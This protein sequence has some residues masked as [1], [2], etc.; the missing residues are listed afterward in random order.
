M[1]KNK[2]MKKF[3]KINIFLISFVLIFMAM[4]I[5]IIDPFFHYHKPFSFLSYKL[6]SKYERYINNGIVKNFDYDA[7][8]T[9]TSMT[10]NFKSSQFDKLFNVNSIKVPFSGGSYKEINDNVETALKNNKDI[11]YILRGLDYGKINEEFNKMFYD[12]YPEYLYDDNI[13]NDYKYFWNEKVLIKNVIKNLKYTL[14]KKETTSFDEYANWEKYYTPGKE[15]VLKTYKRPEK[16]NMEKFLSEEDIKRI[17]K[18]IEENVTKLPKQYPNVKFIYFITP[19]SIVYF[20]ELNQK[21]EIEKQISAE[22]YM[23]QKILE[24]PNI[25]LYSFFNNYEM[26]INLNNYKDAGHY[27]E[28]I[29]EQILVWIKDKKYRL[30]KENYQEYINKNLDFY[31]NYDYESI[32]NS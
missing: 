17:D 6:E 9:G 11:K 21:G 29:N 3:F 1:E 27:M 16:E 28:H 2:K 7:V 23:I 8:I 4:M 30:T 12:S 32:F 15:E 20:D 18:N 31:K 14:L 13:F 10:E 19:Y 5:V 22:K 25:E 24:I 26:I